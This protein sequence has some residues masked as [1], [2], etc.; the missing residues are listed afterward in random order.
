APAMKFATTRV[1]KRRLSC[2]STGIHRH[3]QSKSRHCDAAKSLQ[4]TDCAQ[5]AA[6]PDRMLSHRHSSPPTNRLRQSL[7]TPHTYERTH[8][9]LTAQPDF[10][11]SK[12][13]HFAFLFPPRFAPAPRHKRKFPRIS[14]REP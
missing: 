12:G 2:L 3:L 14:G 8:V 11:F 7:G 9:P 5:A 6:G 13:P 1:E 4:R 10:S